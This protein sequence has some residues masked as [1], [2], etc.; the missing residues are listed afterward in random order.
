MRWHLLPQ[1]R[2]KVSGNLVAIAVAY[3]DLNAKMVQSYLIDHRIFAFVP[4]TPAVPLYPAIPH[5]FL[6]WVS[7]RQRE[8]AVN[9]LKALAE[10]QIPLGGEHA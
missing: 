6:I 9:L 3:D 7:Q 2:Q 5:D 10:S 1:E 4:D 8:E